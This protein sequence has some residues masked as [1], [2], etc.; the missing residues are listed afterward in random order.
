MKYVWDRPRRM[1]ID[2]NTNEPMPLGD[3]AIVTPIIVS[4]LP[5][6]ESP[7]GTGLIEGRAARREDLKKG[8]CR[9][10]DPSEWKPSEAYL[11]KCER[12]EHKAR[13]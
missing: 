5:A 4:D 10:K 8:N 1:F 3:S 12:R 7:L 11:E 9:E 13:A 6:Y 2:P